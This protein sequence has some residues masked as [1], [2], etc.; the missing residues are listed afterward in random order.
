MTAENLKIVIIGGGIAGLTSAA[1]VR[2]NSETADITVIS[3]E[4]ISPYYRLNLIRYLAKEADKESLT[5]YPDSWYEER[6]IKLVGGQNVREVRKETRQLFLEDGTELSY[7]ELIIAN[8]AYP[9][10]PPIKGA[11]LENVITVRSIKDADFLLE[12]MGDLDSCVCIGAGILGLEVAGAIAKND[13]KVTMLESAPWLMPR[14]LNRMGA[15]KLKVALREMGIGVIENAAVEEIIGDNQCE[16]IRLSTGDV[17]KSKVVIITAGVRPDIQ[18]GKTL[19]LKIKDGI[20]VDNHMK[21]SEEHI[22]A[23]GDV[24][25]HD[26]V[27]YGL[28]TV[29]QQQGKIAAQNALGMNTEFSPVPRSNVLKVLGIDM[30]SA[31]VLEVPD[32]NSSQLEAETAESYI[33]FILKEEKIIGSIVYGNKPLS[34]KV[35]FAIDKG[36]RFPK[37]EFQS[38]DSIVKKLLG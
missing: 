5:I 7:D 35:K 13:V 29:A 17:L 10:I 11:E 18:L 9:Y 1:E 20:L 15:E 33:S 21:T 31:G 22:Y 19:G 24:T 32:E 36:Y 14:Q 34:L 28:W 38:V 8:G 4:E 26:G 2:K 6:K 30:F 12:R 3:G 37:E 23:A 25:E 16:G 27:L